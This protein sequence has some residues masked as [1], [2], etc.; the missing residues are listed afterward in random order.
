MVALD[1]SQQGFNSQFLH[2][3]AIFCLKWK[4]QIIRVHVLVARVWV[5]NLYSAEK[6]NVK[7][8]LSATYWFFECFVFTEQT[9]IFR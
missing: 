1:E 8:L 9:D 2:C 3:Y 6:S 4:S 7:K 5:N